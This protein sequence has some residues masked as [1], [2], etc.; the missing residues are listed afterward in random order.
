MHLTPWYDDAVGVASESS[1]GYDPVPIGHIIHTGADTIHDT[2]DL[3][4]DHGG[5]RR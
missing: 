3:V 1:D 5:E 4:A 2:R